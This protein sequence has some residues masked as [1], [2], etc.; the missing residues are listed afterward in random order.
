MTQS[1]QLWGLFGKLF[2]VTVLHRTGQVVCV[3]E[4]DCVKVTWQFSGSGFIHKL[5]DQS[6]CYIKVL[7]IRITS[8]FSGIRGMC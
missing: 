5:S 2:F 4:S 1:I 8:S 3:F 7:D 6:K